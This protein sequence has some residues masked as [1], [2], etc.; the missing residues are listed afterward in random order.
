MIKTC[1]LSEKMEITGI[2]I[3]TP[4]Y[5]RT[6]FVGSLAEYDN[7]NR[8]RMPFETEAISHIYPIYDNCKCIVSYGIGFKSGEYVEVMAET[9]GLIIHYRKK[10]VEV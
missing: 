1:E 5:H 4:Y 9:I 8:S 3:E 10:G 6:Y 2:E 7:A